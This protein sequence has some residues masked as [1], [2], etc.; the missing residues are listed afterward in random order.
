[1]T[2]KHAA[3]GVSRDRLQ[4]GKYGIVG[5]TGYLLNLSVY[6]LLVRGAGIGYLAAAPCAFVAAVTN[7]YVLN[8]IWTFRHQRG[9]FF[10]QGLR[11]FI[12]AI[13][14]LGASLLILI[15]LVRLGVDEVAAQAIA[16]LI[17]TPLNFVS[18]KFWSFSQ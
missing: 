18:N 5:T 11:F 15:S 9:H 12:V 10:H 7:N 3:R 6:A 16:I 14:A 13:C 1:V 17:V 4:I 8:R 2:R